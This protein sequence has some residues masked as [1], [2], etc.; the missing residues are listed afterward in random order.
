MTQWDS[1]QKRGDWVFVSGIDAQH[2]QH[3]VGNYLRRHYGPEAKAI[4][5]TVQGGAFV[6]LAHMP[7]GALEARERRKG[8]ITMDRQERAENL[9]AD[10]SIALREAFKAHSAQPEEDDIDPLDEFDGEYGV[11]DEEDD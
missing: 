8:R 10:K 1:L 5:C 4:C 9:N 3:L 11:G 7:D 2:A 6:A